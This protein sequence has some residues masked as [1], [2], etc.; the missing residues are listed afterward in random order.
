MAALLNAPKKTPSDIMHQ[1]A[2]TIPPQALDFL[3]QQYC[4]TRG[5]TIQREQPNTRRYHTPVGQSTKTDKPPS[6]KETRRDA[7]H[8]SFSSPERTT[9]GNIPGAPQKGVCPRTP[10][11]ST[12][13]QKAPDAPKKRRIN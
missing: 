11:Q 8:E 2:L 5:R 3:L 1:R 4:H 13:E 10:L 7:I 6:I 12:E 9:N